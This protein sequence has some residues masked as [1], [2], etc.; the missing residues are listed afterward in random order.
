MCS[1]CV[2]SSRFCQRPCLDQRIRDP[3]AAPPAVYQTERYGNLTYTIAG[4]TTGATYKVRLHFAEFYW[5]NAGQRRFNVSIN[6]TQF[7]NNFDIIAVAGAPNK[8]T[9]QEFTTTANSSG[10]IVIT[11]TTITDNAKASGIEIIGN[12]APVITV[13]S[14]AGGVAI[15]NNTN[16]T[17]ILNATVTDDSPVVTT[18]WSQ[19]S[20]PGPVVFGTSNAPITTAGFPQTGVY[21]LRLTA[22]DG[23]L[24]SSQDITVVADP[25]ATFGSGLAAYWKFDEVADTT[26]DDSSGSGLNATVSSSTLWTNAGYINGA[27]NIAGVAANNINAGHPSALNNLFTNGATVCAYINPASAGGGTLGRIMD[28]SGGGWIL[29]NQTLSSGLLQLR[30]E[31]AFTNSRTNKWQ[32]DNLAPTGSWT[33]VVVSYNSSSPTNSPAI[34]INGLAASLADVSAGPFSLANT[35][36]NDSTTDLFIGNR[37]DTLRAFDGRIDDVRVYRRA[38]GRAEAFA[39]ALLP[40]ANRAPSVDAGTNQIGVV[41]V[42]IALTATASDDGA[43]TTTWSKLSGLGNVTFGNA[44]VTNTTAVF[45][46]AGVCVLR[47]T[48]DDGQ[49]Q[50]VSSMSVTVYATAYDAWVASYGLTGNDALPDADL[51]GDGMNNMQEFLSGTNPTDSGSVFRIVSV[52]NEGNDTRVVW[53]TTT[54][55]DYTLEVSSPLG[56][57]STNDFARIFSVTN[58]VGGATNYLDVGAASS[59]A[60]YY[61][62]HLGP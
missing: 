44:G 61:R 31:Q 11:Y 54:G 41:D 30:F 47:L 13:S 4:L 58:A 26:A 3:N 19:V 42:P 51:D 17:L 18:S 8:G 57:F 62:V 29:F 27:V 5:G 45:D 1:S 22:S 9:I 6:G 52:A 38:L 56:G 2:F 12:N 23:S 55:H 39:L 59:G 35:A 37:Q 24:Q 10:Q 60:R 25:N 32:I 48:G 16:A 21:V 40:A 20:G 34:Y 43:F 33:H 14:P 36:L 28:K 53:T 15:L 49:Q 46:S 50:V 7:L